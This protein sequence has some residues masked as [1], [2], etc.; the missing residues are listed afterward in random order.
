MPKLERSQ[1]RWLVGL[2]LIQIEQQKT[3]LL[4][5]ILAK[6]LKPIPCRVIKGS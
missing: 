4:F 2:K 1:L 5:S 3:R 6:I